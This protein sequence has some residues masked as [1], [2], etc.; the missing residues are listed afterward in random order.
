[1]ADIS[2]NF[3]VFTNL[4]PEHLDYHPSME[5]YYQAKSRLFKMLTIDGVAIINSSDLNGK[6]LQK[7][8]LPQYYF[9]PE[10]MVIQYIFLIQI[11]P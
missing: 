7:R 10:E 2:F 4:T 3:A 5:A 6:E 1:M 8:Q 9:F 11:Q